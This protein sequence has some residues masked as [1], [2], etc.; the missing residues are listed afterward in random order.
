MLDPKRII[1][2]ITARKDI[3]SGIFISIFRID[4]LRFR[5][6]KDLCLGWWNALASSWFPASAILKIW[7][8]GSNF[9]LVHA[10]VHEK[11]QTD[12]REVDKAVHDNIFEVLIAGSLLY[13]YSW[14]PT[15]LFYLHRETSIIGS[16]WHVSRGAAT[17]GLSFREHKCR[18]GQ[19]CPFSFEDIILLLTVDWIQ[20]ALFL[21]IAMAAVSWAVCWV[22]FTD[23]TS[24]DHFDFNRLYST[25]VNKV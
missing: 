19:I 6:W 9:V 23:S 7:H 13:L 4:S 21:I 2:I 10:I 8:C 1:K 15:A 22:D 17:L 16:C 24:A 18:N 12:I 25:T 3:A 20:A 5:S 11:S 14:L